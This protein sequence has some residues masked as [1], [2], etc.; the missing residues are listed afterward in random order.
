M[1]KSLPVCIDC[2]GIPSVAGRRNAR[3]GR[4]L[5]GTQR[6]QHQTR[7]L[8]LTRAA[9]SRQAVGSNPARGANLRF[10]NHLN[11]ARTFGTE[12]KGCRSISGSSEAI[13]RNR[14]IFYVISQNPVSGQ[15]INFDSSVTTS[16]FYKGESQEKNFS[17]DWK[18][19][20]CSPCSPAHFVLRASGAFVCL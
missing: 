10:L 15:S 18:E 6:K 8:D 3:T 7:H 12:P 4:I 9:F 11:V 17:G 1:R 2:A 13:G 20:R 5:G 16:A 19:R 14:S